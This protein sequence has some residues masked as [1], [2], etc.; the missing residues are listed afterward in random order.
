MDCLILVGLNKI[1]TPS[2]RCDFVQEYLCTM[3]ATLPKI[4]IDTDPF[5][6]EPWRLFFHYHYTDNN[7]FGYPHGYAIQTEW[8]HWFKRDTPQCILSPMSLKNYLYR[9]YASIDPLSS[10]FRLTPVSSETEEWYLEAKRYVFGMD[11]PKHREKYPDYY[12]W[13]KENYTPHYFKPKSMLNGLTKLCNRKLELDFSEREKY[14]LFRLNQ[15][16]ELPQ[17]PIYKFIIEENRRRM[18]IY[19]TIANVRDYEWVE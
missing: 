14:D 2:N 11:E 15:T 6:G 12:A 7:K 9:T 18:Q 1:V 4:S 3:T 5:L 8:K 13:F 17:L 10:K 16:I 19:N